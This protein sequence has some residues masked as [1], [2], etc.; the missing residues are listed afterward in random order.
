MR[1]ETTKGEKMKKLTL[2]F[3]LLAG[4]FVIPPATTAATTTS[5][6]TETQQIYVGVGQPRRRYRGRYS[7]VRT[8]VVYRMGRRYRETYR[9]T[10]WPNGR[11]STQ[12]ISR[13]VLGGRR[14]YRNY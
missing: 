8:R 3:T 10:Y 2:L 5:N 7:V 6:V 11:M 1:K 12:L 14:Y 4:L 9:V 13:V